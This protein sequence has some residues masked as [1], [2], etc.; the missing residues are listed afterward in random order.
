MGGEPKVSSIGSVLISRLV[1]QDQ[2][3][4]RGCPAK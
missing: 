1:A 4:N 3:F 2:T